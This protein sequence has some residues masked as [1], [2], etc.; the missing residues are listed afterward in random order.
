MKLANYLSNYRSSQ[1][2]Q[3]LQE[4]A[5]AVI[6]DLWEAAFGLQEQ[7]RVDTATYGLDKWEE[8]LGIAQG[9]GMTNEARRERLIAKLRG[10]GTSTVEMIQKTI[11]SFGTGPVEVVEQNSEYKF[12]VL[13]ISIKGRPAQMDELQAAVERIKPA[14]LGVDYVFFLTTH[15]ELKAYTHQQLSAYTHLEIETLEPPSTQG[16]E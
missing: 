4:G 2:Y 3:G 16:G 1:E 9:I 12:S 5:Q 8:M 6:D 7:I 10:T 13:F 14:H 11:E 15:Q